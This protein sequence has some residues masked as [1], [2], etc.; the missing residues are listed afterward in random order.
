MQARFYLPM[1]GRFASPDP[2]RD[3]HF[4]ETQSWNIYSYVR[5]MPTMSIDP[6][7]MLTENEKKEAA[8]KA[9]ADAA[10]KSQTYHSETSAFVQ[11]TIYGDGKG[12]LQHFVSAWKHA[13]SDPEWWFL[14]STSVASYFLAGGQAAITASHVDEMAATGVK[15]SK[16]SLVATGRMPGGKVAFL[17]TGTA[18]SGLQHIVERHAQD[19]ANKGIPQS[20]IPR[21]VMDSVTRGQMVGTNG[22]SPVYRLKVNGVTQYIK[23]T[24][25]SNGYIVQSNPV[26][27][28][29]PVPLS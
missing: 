17:E 10:A 2:A 22:G 5:N 26:S 27:T 15:F 14:A 28:W 1:W 4:E 13:V 29:K 21:T 12:A 23:T 20:Q 6:T 25:G 18:E 7:G 9:A 11:S 16:E 24:V 3:Q 8:E 19:F